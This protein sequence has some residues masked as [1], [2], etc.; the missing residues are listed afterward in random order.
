[1]RARLVAAPIIIGIVLVLATC[2]LHREQSAPALSAQKSG[3]TVMVF[4]SEA[5]GPTPLPSPLPHI[6]RPILPTVPADLLPT[7]TPQRGTPPTPALDATRIPRSMLN[8]ENLLVLGSDQRKPGQPWRT[9]VIMVVAIDRANER[10]GVVSI[11]RDLW[12]NIPGAGW[13]RVNTA[14]FYGSLRKDKDGKPGNGVE[15]LK[16]TLQQNLGIP[17]HHYVRVDFDVFRGAVDALGGITVTVDCPLRD[18][19]WNKPGQ[20]GRLEP[21]EYFMNGE[22]A[23]IFVR[24]RHTGGDLDRARRQQRVLLAMRKRALE[25][26]LWPRVPTLYR[27]FHDKVFTDLGPLD[28]IELARLGLRLQPENIHGFVIGRPMVRDW[29]TSGGAM[30]LVPDYPRIRKALDTLFDSPPLLITNDKTGHCP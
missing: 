4:P 11:P 22:E 10:V 28:M 24:T 23:L 2:S 16:K 9:D 15:L 1:M 18:P 30:V 21:G 27:E 7:P 25:I 6:V 3:R 8:T 20:R 14:D 26:N 5:A 12:V 19:L 29:I 13:E 17:I